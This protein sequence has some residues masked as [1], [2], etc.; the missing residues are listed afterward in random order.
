MEGGVSMP[1]PRSIIPPPAFFS[2][3]VNINVKL[4]S[5]FGF[6]M[7]TAVVAMRFLL[8]VIAESGSGIGNSVFPRAQ[9][10]RSEPLGLPETPSPAIAEL[11]VSRKLVAEDPGTVTREAFSPITVVTRGFVTMLFPN[12]R[13]R[14]HANDAFPASTSS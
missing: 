3:V 4:T 2:K 1:L 7:T 12:L 9:P 11:V 13:D 10:S 6:A 14:T 5:T 8:S